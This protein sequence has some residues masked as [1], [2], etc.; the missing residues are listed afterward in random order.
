MG[1]LIVGYLWEGIKTKADVK[2]ALEKYPA[3]RPPVKEVRAAIGLKESLSNFEGVKVF[4]EREVPA[5]HIFLVIG[6]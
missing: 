3:D 6:E 1:E 4:F 5:E 2:Y